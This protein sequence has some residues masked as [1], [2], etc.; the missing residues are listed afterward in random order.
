MTCILMKS[1]S[2]NKHT[3]EENIQMAYSETRKFKTESLINQD[4]IESI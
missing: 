3:V 2:L 4:N 1:K